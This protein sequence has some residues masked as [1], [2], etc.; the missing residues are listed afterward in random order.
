[1]T[2]WEALF[3]RLLPTRPA[4]PRWKRLARRTGF[5]HRRLRLESLEARTLLAGNITI[6]TGGSATLAQ[7]T[8]GFSDPTNYTVD[9]S[10]LNTGS[11]AIVLQ[12]TGNITVSNA[13]S[14]STSSRA[15][16]LEANGSLSLNAGISTNSGDL[17]LQDHTTGGFSIGG[18]I[19]LGTGNLRILTTQGVTQAA[20]GII[21][22]AGLGVRDTVSGTIQLTQANNFQTLAATSVGSIVVNDGGHALSVGSVTAD[23]TGTFSALSGV[24]TTNSDIELYTSTFGSVAL[25]QAVSA[26]TGTVRI[27]GDGGLTE[28]GSGAITAASLGVRIGNNT[29]TLKGANNIG[30]FATN[31]G[32]FGSTLAIVNGSNDLAIG[33]VSADS[34]GLFAAV[35]G[36]TSTFF[37]DFTFSARAISITQPVSVGGTYLRFVTTGGVSES[38]SGTISCNTLGIRN[39]TAGNVALTAV[40]ASTLAVSQTAPSGTITWS[41]A[42]GDLTVGTV[43]ADTNGLFTAL[44]GVS[45]SSGNITVTSA[46][47]I[48]NQS[49]SI[50]SGGDFTIT[51]TGFTDNQSINIGSGTLRVQSTTG[52]LQSGSGSITAGAMSITSSDVFANIGLTLNNNISTFAASSTNSGTPVSFTSIASGGLTIGSVP[53]GGGLAAVSGITTVNG[54]VSVIDSTEVTVNQ[55]IASSGG[56]VTITT[57]SL[58]INQSVSAGAAPVALTVATSNRAISLG[59]KPGNSLGLLNSELAQ[60]TASV[61]RVGSATTGNVTIDSAITAPAGWNSLTLNSGA[62]ISQSATLTVASLCV[63]SSGTAVVLTGAN[64][65]STL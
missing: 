25:S 34:A 32:T 38:G 51:S 57:D 47:F 28:S 49:V 43:T 64:A 5:F 21:T 3:S 62:A 53:A 41:N 54:A 10:T 26:G 12:A 20:S 44:S 8:A 15:L 45:T 52:A 4:L 33:S 40:S 30:T 36:A 55:A 9:P 29:I 46:N 63:Q 27:T 35:S 58:S 48:V 6:A 2:A 65:I 19:S 24:T 14:I 7:V 37:A 13:V 1:M 60:V 56:T 17:L 31:M 23:G 11:G 39:T 59:T 61:L 18:A 16:A 22:A 50:G 42:S